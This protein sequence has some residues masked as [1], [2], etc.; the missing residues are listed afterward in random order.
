MSTLRRAFRI[1]SPSKATAEIGM[2]VSLGL[3]DGM[4]DYAS[5]VSN[6]AR[7]VATKALDTTA[8]AIKIGSKIGSAY[9]AAVQSN[10]DIE[11]VKSALSGTEMIAA[12]ADFSGASAYRMPAPKT[13]SHAWTG[14]RA[15]TERVADV[16]TRAVIQSLVTTNGVGTAQQQGDTVI[17]LKAGEEELARATMRGQASLARR[18]VLDLG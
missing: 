3:A 9:G 4:M 2:Y 16:I 6:S 13:A 1:H 11:G 10:I 7:S 12:N 5:R 8:E 14:D 17:V 15:D 18:G